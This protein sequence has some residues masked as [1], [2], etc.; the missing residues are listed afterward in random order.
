[1]IFLRLNSESSYFYLPICLKYKN[2]LVKIII[3]NILPYLFHDQSS[4]NITVTSFNIK[5]V[6]L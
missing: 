1:M 6:K 5:L 2:I 4:I 3:L